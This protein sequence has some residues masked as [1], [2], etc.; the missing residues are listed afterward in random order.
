MS[1][2]SLSD[3]VPLKLGNEERERAWHAKTKRRPVYPAPGLPGTAW[4]YVNIYWLTTHTLKTCGVCSFSGRLCLKVSL[5]PVDLLVLWAVV[6]AGFPGAESASTLAHS[7]I[8]SEFS[9]SPAIG[10]RTSVPG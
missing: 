3:K 5:E 8:E 9:S 1:R 2:E 6:S 10:L 4:H 7:C